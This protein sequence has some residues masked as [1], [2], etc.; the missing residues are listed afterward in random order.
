M[1]HDFAAAQVNTIMMD[2]ESENQVAQ[3][4]SSLRSLLKAI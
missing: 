4:F 3:Y 1:Y 2:P